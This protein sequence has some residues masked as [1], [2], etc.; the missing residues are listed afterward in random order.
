MELEPDNIG[1][2]TLLSNLQASFGQWN[3]VEEVKRVMNEKNLKKKP[4]W[5]CTEAKGMIHGF[6]SAVDDTIK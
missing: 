3:E 4:R 1:Y 5:S 6:V 2:H